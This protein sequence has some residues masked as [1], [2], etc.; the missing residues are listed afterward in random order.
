MATAQ[1]GFDAVLNYMIG[2]VGGGGTWTEL[3]NMQD[4]KLD[5]TSDEA[6]VT[7]R[8]SGGWK[9]TAAAIKDASV[10][11]DMIWDPTNAGFT[12]IKDAYFNNTV[13]GLQILDKAAGEGLEADFVITNFSRN[14]PVNDVLKVSVTAK[15]SFVNTPPVW[16]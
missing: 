5:L 12:A 2:G 7:V 8:G 1:F 14:E 6:D 9:A 10:S 16:I 4:N 11:F 15:V 3:K 13:I